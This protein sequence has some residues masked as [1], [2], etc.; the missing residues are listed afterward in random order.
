MVI[1]F[2]LFFTFNLNEPHMIRLLS[3]NTVH[4]DLVEPVVYLRG[5]HQDDT[6]TTVK[7]A[8]ILNLQ[9]STLF[10]NITVRLLG[11]S[12]TAW[13][14]G[15]PT[16]VGGQQRRFGSSK[17]FIDSIIPIYPTVQSEAERLMILSPG[18]YRYPFEL[19][20]PNSLPESVNFEEAKVNYKL[21]ATLEKEKRQGNSILPGFLQAKVD[22]AEQEINLVRLA[23]DAVFTSDGLRESITAHHQL[24][25]LC[26]Y[27]IT[28]EKSAISPGGILPVSVRVIPH[29]KGMRIEYV[30]VRL[31]ERRD[32]KIPEKQVQDSLEKQHYLRRQDHAKMTVNADIDELGSCWEDRIVFVVPE[33][34]RCPNLHHSTMAHPE[35]SVQHWL[36]VT[37]LVAYPGESSKPT[38]RALVLDTK[39]TVLNECVSSH[40]DEDCV[41]LPQYQEASRD[42]HP[43]KSHNLQHYSHGGYCAYELVEPNP[44]QSVRDVFGLPLPPPAYDE[45]ID[46]RGV[47]I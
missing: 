19:C 45:Q 11:Q 34:D 8:V 15:G 30:H 40:A 46:I 47:S 23:S 13:E 21:I 29:L 35:I 2:Y 18:R 7:G 17:T 20:L 41:A 1:T 24:P 37:V 12:T 43:R 36:Q 9:D 3:K 33:A 44:Q 6:H 42:D 32:L 10:K 25:D 16:G 39:I 22:T 26:D 4:I 31:Q 27:H 14:E 5:S 38:Q 28:V